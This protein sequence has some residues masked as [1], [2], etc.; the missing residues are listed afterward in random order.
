MEGREIGDYGSEGDDG[1]GTMDG[2]L[3]MGDRV[4]ESM[5]ELKSIGVGAKLALARPG[6]SGRSMAC[7]AKPDRAKRGLFQPSEASPAGTH[8]VA[9]GMVEFAPVHHHSLSSSFCKPYP[10]AH[11]K[12]CGV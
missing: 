8:Q 3:W 6:M 12:F 4:W 11:V 2:R 9:Y 7:R 5:V 10:V 1:W